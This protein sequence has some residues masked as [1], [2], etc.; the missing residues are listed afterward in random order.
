MSE[1]LEWANR[2]WTIAE[3][4]GSWLAHGHRYRRV[5][6]RDEDYRSAIFDLVKI[7]DDW[8]LAGLE[9]IDPIL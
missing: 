9:V 3:V 8:R 6:A 2:T 4:Q 1:T 7:E 5:L